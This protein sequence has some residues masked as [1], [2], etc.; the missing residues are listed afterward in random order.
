MDRDL[1]KDLE[2]CNAATPGPWEWQEDRWNGGYSGMSGA[3]DA[4]VIYPSH[5]ND[6]DDGAAWFDDFP[7]EADR[8]FIAAAREGWPHAI[9][10]AI[11]AEAEVKE[12]DAELDHWKAHYGDLDNKTRQLIARLA[13]AE[14]VCEAARV[15]QR[16]NPGYIYEGCID[17]TISMQFLQL[18]LAV[19]EE[20]AE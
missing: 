16:N 11:D 8:L 18:A 13:A 4:S 17:F 10:R 9:K 20:G 19:Y 1:P 12:L 6:G 3:E 7:S 15:V 14:K 5:C 2:I